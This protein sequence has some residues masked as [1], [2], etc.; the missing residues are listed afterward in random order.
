VPPFLFFAAAST[1]DA[2]LAEEYWFGMGEQD[3]KA[4]EAEELRQ[5]QQAAEQGGAGCAV[6][7]AAVCRGLLPRLQRRHGA[8]S[9]GGWDNPT[10]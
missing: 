8:C 5:R 2:Q 7:G 3:Q 9:V 1:S 10:G 6:I 4:G